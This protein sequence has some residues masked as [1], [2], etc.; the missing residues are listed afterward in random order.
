MTLDQFVDQMYAQFVRE[1]GQM[2]RTSLKEKRLKMRVET[3][4]V[5]AIQ[6]LQR[7]YHTDRGFHSQIHDES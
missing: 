2:A 3:V 1:D 6:L 5:E 4:M 7:H